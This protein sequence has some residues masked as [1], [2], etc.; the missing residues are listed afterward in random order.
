MEHPCGGCVHYYGYYRANKC[1]N[2]LFDT[3]HRRPCPP[4]AAC[5]VKTLRPKG[6]AKRVSK[7]NRTQV[8]NKEVV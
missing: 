7:A 8:A 3:D 6:G 5:T 4:G 2:F 1:C